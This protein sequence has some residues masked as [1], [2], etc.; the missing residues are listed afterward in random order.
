MP[1]RDKIHSFLSRYFRGYALQDD[2][3]IFALGFVNSLFAMK[4]VSF[5]ESELGVSV[6]QDDLD[7]ENFRTVS[8]MVAFVQRRREASHGAAAGS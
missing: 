4:L 2:E 8:A 3:D 6:E 7:I 5:I 1:P